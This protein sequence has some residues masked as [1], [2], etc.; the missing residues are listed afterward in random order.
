MLRIPLIPNVP[1]FCETRWV[2]KHKSIRIFH[3]H[4]DE[5]FNV[6]YEMSNGKNCNNSKTRQTALTL[7]HAANNST[8]FVC[9]SIIAKYSTILEPIIV[10][11]QAK[12]VNLLEM[13]GKITKMITV[14]ESHRKDE[15]LWNDFNKN[16]CESAENVGIEIKPPRAPKKQINRSNQ[17]N[18]NSNTFYKRSIYFPYLDS[19][20][21]SLRSRFNDSNLPLYNLLLLFVSRNN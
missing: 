5:I 15:D 8:F 2:Q 6:L 10:A 16:T 12:Q 1:T 20:L 21:M 13:F 11:L 3:K 14:F 7:Y 9:L 17:P 18:D 19:I 4:F